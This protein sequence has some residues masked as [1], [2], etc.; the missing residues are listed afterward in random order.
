MLK[1]KPKNKKSKNETPTIFKKPIQSTQQNIPIR[2][3]VDGVVIT[4]DNQYVKTIEILPI[5]FFLK[6]P[7]EQS[8]I[9]DQFKA[10]LKICPDDVRTP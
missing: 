10:V 1:R 6:K 2:D 3:I 9:F 5:P 4:T 8:Q 7:A